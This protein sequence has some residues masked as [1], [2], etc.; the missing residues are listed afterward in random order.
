MALDPDEYQRF[1]LKERKD[2]THNTHIYRF[3]LHR[4]DDVLGLPIGQH[5]SFRYF[6]RKIHYSVV[7]MTLL[8]F[9]PGLLLMGKR[10]IDHTPQLVPMMIWVTL[11]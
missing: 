9:S 6:L 4:E 11:I 8:F 7:F 10:F 2:I 5:M 1:A 3:A